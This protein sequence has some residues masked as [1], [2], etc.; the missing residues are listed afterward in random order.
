LDA[1][2]E[3]GE[4]WVHHEVLKG[5]TVGSANELDATF[6]DRSR[7][8]RFEFGANFVNH[9]DFGHVVFDCFNHDCVLHRGRGHLHAARAADRGMRDIAVAADLI[10]GVNDNDTL[11]RVIGEDASDFTQHSGLANAWP[12]EEQRALAAHNEILD[13]A[14]RSVDSTPDPA[15]E[16]DNLSAPVPDAGDAME[17]AFDSRA[18][19]EPEFADVFDHE[20][21]VRF[22][23]FF[24]AEYNFAAR[25]P[26]FGE[27]AEIHDDFQQ[28]GAP[29][30]FAEQITDARWKGGEQ[31]IEVIGHDLFGHK[32][33]AFDFE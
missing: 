30:F 15:C 27:A 4:R 18:V 22:A 24:M 13:H 5:H 26:C 33:W 28:A 14:D 19:I 3:V 16:P 31:Q 20:L 7:G 2:D 32:G 10:R 23:D 8:G 12:A 29:L 1:A 25:V 11:V 21:E 17:R 6:G 9:D